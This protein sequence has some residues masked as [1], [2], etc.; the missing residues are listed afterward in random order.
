M[1]ETYDAIVVGGGAMGTAAART[2]AQRGRQTLLLERFDIAHAR[3][4][5]GGPTRIFRLTYDHP[6]YVRMARLALDAWHELEDAADERLLIATAGLDIGPD[7][8]SSAAALEAAGEPFEYLAPG[9]VTERWPAVRVAPD[10]EVFVQEDGGVIMSERTVRAQARLAAAAGVTILERAPVERIEATGIDATVHTAADTYR[11]PIVVVT[12]GPWAGPLLGTAG[13]DLPLV[14]SLEQVTYFELEAPSPLP[15]VIDWTV[16]PPSTPYTVP[17]PEE[18]GAFKI[19]FHMSGP[20]VDADDGPFDADPERVRRAIEYAPTRYAAPRPTGITD[21]CLYTN[22]PDEHFVLD[23]RRSVVIGSPC[24][25]HGFKFT[26][27][28]G[29][30]LADL[31]TAQPAPIPIERFLAL[32][33]D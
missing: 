20:S 1:A 19:A 26:P 15:T 18:P 16:T 32:R 14:P 25:G 31:A 17:N 23:R 13:V 27:L 24:S 4:S 12:A 21:T 22:T 6:D 8:R 3:G 7:G 30:I 11:A 9:A 28:L 29:R 10:E 2:L 5:S 33:F